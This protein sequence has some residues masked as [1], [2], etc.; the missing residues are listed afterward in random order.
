MQNQPLILRPKA[1]C[2]ELGI[3]NTTFWRLAKSGKLKV[4]NISPRLTGVRR[5]D[6]KA[7]LDAQAG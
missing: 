2:A 3:S 6:L 1:V 4:I 5:E 7:Y